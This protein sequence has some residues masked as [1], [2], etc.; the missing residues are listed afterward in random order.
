MN[1]FNYQRNPQM[2]FEACTSLIDSNF[3]LLDEALILV[4]SC[5]Y[6]DSASKPKGLPQLLSSFFFRLYL[7][8]VFDTWCISCSRGRCSSARTNANQQPL[9]P[10][11]CTTA[12]FVQS[13]LNNVVPPFSWRFVRQRSTPRTRISISSAVIYNS[14]YKMSSFFGRRQTATRSGR[15]SP[16]LLSP[17]ASKLQP[18]KTSVN[19]LYHLDVV[20]ATSVI[21][22]SVLTYSA[23][24]APNQSMSPMSTSNHP[25]APTRSQA[26]P[27]PRSKTVPHRPPP[28]S[29]FPR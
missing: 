3:R 15:S 27:P 10:Y 9:F 23:P 13:S 25:S 7:R 22:P 28:V 12:R 18:P 2:L 29:A 16:N 26:V 24:Q 17:N 1:L 8:Q 14:V 19:S 20:D 5:S 4:Q 21:I 11:V 6:K